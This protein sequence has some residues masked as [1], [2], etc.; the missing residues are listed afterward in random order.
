MK[1]KMCESCGMPM[2]KDPNGG[3]TNAD[4]SKNEQYCSYC[5]QNG[6]FTWKGKVDDF[7][8]FCKEQMIKSGMNRFIA[9]LFTRNM[10]RLPR[11]K[12]A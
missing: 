8:E 4:G 12:N 9:W 1:T 2:S 5:Y 10:K 11:W 3:G 6:D 7:Q